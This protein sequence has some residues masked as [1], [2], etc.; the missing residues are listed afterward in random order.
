[1][2]NRRQQL[3]SE[4]I[5]YYQDVLGFKLDHIGINFITVCLENIELFLKKHHD[6]GSDNIA[7]FGETGVLIRMHDKLSRLTNLIPKGDSMFESLDDTWRDTS[8]YAS[9][10]LMCRSGL[11]DPTKYDL[12]KEAIE[13][14]KKQEK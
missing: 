7:A 11:W 9:I 10:G 13:Y 2:D 3:S 1:M 5:Q 4:L 14:G 8:I 6:Y 12:I